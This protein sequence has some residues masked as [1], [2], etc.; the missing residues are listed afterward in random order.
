MGKKL[1]YAA[2]LMILEWSAGGLYAQ[3]EFNTWY[4]GQYAG[5]DFNNGA[6]VALSG[7]QVYTNEG[8][9]TVSDGAG[10]LL[11]Y[12]DG[13]RVWNKNHSPMPNGIGLMGDFSSTQ[14]A[15]IV[16]QPANPSH[17]FIFTSPSQVGNAGL[18]YSEV[19][20]N[21]N[22]GLG[23]VTSKN[24]PLYPN[25]CEKICAVRH[26]NNKDVWVITHEYNSDAFRTFL[27]T[28]SGVNATPV[29]SHAG[30]TIT[31]SNSNSIGY[32]KV[33]PDGR[34]LASA[35]YNPMN[36]FELFDFN[37]TNGVV[38]NGIT[39]GFFGNGAYG[40]EFSPDGTK[41]Y[42]SSWDSGNIIQFD[43]CAGSNSSIAASG[44]NIAF[45]ASHLGG[46]QLGPDNKIY[47]CRS[48]GNWLGVINVPNASGSACNYV[49]NGIYLNGNFSR[50]GLP[51]R[52]IY[53]AL[54]PPPP[55]FMVTISCLTAT[56]LAP[57][58]PSGNCSN[59]PNAVASV[60]WDFGDPQSG[61]SD[62]SS[63]SNPTHLFSQEGSYTVT[64]ILNYDC[65]SDTIRQD[66]H[67]SLPELIIESQDAHCWNANG[68]AIA[69]ISGGTPP[70]S[71]SWMPT[72]LTTQ[73]VTGLAP[74]NYSVVITDNQGCSQTSSVDIHSTLPP[75]ADAGSDV[76]VNVGE[77]VAL[78]AS[79][80]TAYQWLNAAGLSC[81]HCDDP[82]VSP[83]ENTTY[84]VIVSDSS[85]CRDTDC[86][87]VNVSSFYIPNAFSPNND[88]L[89][90]RF[91]PSIAEVHNYEFS[92]FNRWGEKIFES[93][94]PDEGW[95]GNYKGEKCEE[96]VYVYS[97]MFV[98]NVRKA[99]HQLTGHVTLLR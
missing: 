96:G 68:V 26:C 54:T 25:T 70:F 76:T 63:I 29:I 87:N 72:G 75:V 15:V 91:R 62:T 65:G 60:L 98:D 56:F 9:A 49:D 80:G 27:V 47:V 90:D 66:I 97:V 64:L 82:I 32:L 7:G 3:G 57:V 95:D 53:Y 58:I 23:D 69:N 11:F 2:G 17:Y 10:N 48:V 52:V 61:T 88:D 34:K 8:C 85:G 79:G 4:F 35:A 6:P 19:N 21:L 50:L 42:C 86:V 83:L 37:K 39:L 12:T 5:L 14:S 43:L 71:Y 55:P 24:I 41:L 92:V 44:V 84:C 31:G 94:D 46:M 16:Q 28:A 51:D 22:G 20:M 74:G 73:N 18:R 59:A 40:V 45:S 36:R 89:N 33:S 77:G 78:H 81:S 38:S 99:M 30:M 13:V 93:T 67:L 1:L